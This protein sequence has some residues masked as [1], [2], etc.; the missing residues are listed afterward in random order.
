MHRHNVGVAFNHVASVFVR[1]CLPG[2]VDTVYYPALVVYLRL[3]RIEILGALRISFK[4]P[5]PEPENLSRQRMDG[6]HYPSAEPV[7]DLLF[8][9]DRQPCFYKQLC[10]ESAIYCLL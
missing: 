3:R 6:E 8:M 7:K 10:L 4:Y 9:L 2:L 5:S 1:Y